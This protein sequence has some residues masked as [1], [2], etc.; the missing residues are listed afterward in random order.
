MLL[1]VGIEEDGLELRDARE[2]GWDEGLHSALFVIAD[3]LTAQR[4]PPGCRVMPFR[5][6][7]ESSM[8]ELQSL[9]E[10]SGQR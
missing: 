6:V 4:I 7:A 9:L 3:S 1:A 10:D 8:V 2:I 5:V